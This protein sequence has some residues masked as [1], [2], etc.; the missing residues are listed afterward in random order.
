MHDQRPWGYFEVILEEDNYKVKRIVIQPGQRLSLQRHR[1][2]YEHWVIVSGEAL[3]TLDDGI[4][5]LD[6]GE[7]ILIPKRSK[8]RITC[9]GKEPV[10]LIEVQLGEYLG[11]DDIERFED[12]YGRVLV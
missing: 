1:Q 12:D 7:H 6:C 11:E 3:V 10:V 2:R 4:R 5:P 8:H 9:R